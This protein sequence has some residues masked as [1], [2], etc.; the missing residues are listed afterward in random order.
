[1]HEQNI[2][3]KKMN[4]YLF[5]KSIY[6][7]ELKRRIDLDNSINIPITILTLVV[8]LNTIYIYE[9]F[10]RELGIIQ[11]L[12]IIIGVTILI[13][14]FFII[15][16][17]NNLFKGFKYQNLPL[18]KEIREYETKEIP[19]YNSKVEEE[20]KLSFEDYI[21]NQLIETTDSHISFRTTIICPHSIG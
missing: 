20:H 4:A 2:E 14:I 7:R 8:G 11:F 18:T 12:S 10:F 19:E 6:D 5:Y 17:Y 15:K 9:F 13:S 21:I 16:S 1:M 3:D